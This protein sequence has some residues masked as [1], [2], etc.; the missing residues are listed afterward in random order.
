MRAVL[1]VGGKG[2]RVRPFSYI[3]PKPMLP[4]G[5]RPTLELLLRQLAKNGFDEVTLS[6]GYQGDL[7]KNFF[8]DGSKFGVKLTYSEEKERLGTAGHL[9][10]M[11]D[12]PK[13]SFLVMNGDMLAATD[14]KDLFQKH[15]QSKAAM[16]VVF[17]KIKNTVEYAVPEIDAD[18]RVVRYTEKPT[19]E[20][21]AS[22]GMYVLE[23]KV[24]DY[25]EYNKFLDMPDLIKKLIDA[26]EKVNSYFITG[27]WLFLKR[28][29][30][31]EFANENWSEL[32]KDF[33]LQEFANGS[34][35]AK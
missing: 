25:I 30:D 27:T 16:T 5:E 26:K 23:P 9:S 14:F 31:F 2:M 35:S 6:L 15:K 28:R 34:E 21:N 18:G 24:L 3:L 8:G 22:I 33:G 7:I 13:D 19:T 20:A 32:A 17:K 12:K 4:I 1:M 29:E 10:L 11:K